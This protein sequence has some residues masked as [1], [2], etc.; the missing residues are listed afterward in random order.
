MLAARVFAS[1]VASDAARSARACAIVAAADAGNAL[2]FRLFNDG[3][4][5]L[6]LALALLAPILNHAIKSNRGVDE[7]ATRLDS[8]VFTDSRIG[9]FSYAFSCAYIL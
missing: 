1:A 8:T 7:R 6:P 5:A 3:T 4:T 2:L 9:A